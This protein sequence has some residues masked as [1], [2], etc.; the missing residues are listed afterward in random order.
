MADETVTTTEESGVAESAEAVESGAS[1]EGVTEAT[2]AAEGAAP[3]DG[4]QGEAPAQRV[5][6]A[7]ERIQ[8]LLEKN[9]TLSEQLKTKQAEAPAKRD[10]PPTRRDDYAD[11]RQSWKPALREHPGLK[12][13]EVSEDGLVNLHGMFVTSEFAA[14]HLDIAEGN[15]EAREYRQQQE[16]AAREQAERRNIEE[17]AE[18]YSDG[19][20]A[21][22]ES[23]FPNLPK[24]Q[25]EQ[26]DS[27]LCAMA[28][29]KI[30]QL[31]AQG[32]QI[33]S[34]VL[35]KVALEVLAEAKLLFGALGVAQMTGNT[36][37][38]NQNKVK[39]GGTPGTTKPKSIVDMTR[40]ERDEYTKWAAEE[41]VR[42]T[43]PG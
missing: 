17:I 35:G 9:K 4:S 29:Q 43:S 26:V 10:E 38:A 30:G 22:R 18:A 13:L 12:E 24:G 31:N 19:I 37:Y 41:A 39:P 20:S 8:Q 40:A 34:D 2:K 33:T 25:G 21:M 3:D 11:P 15:K 16:T 23:E 1:V 5:S 42:I 32:Q 14:H 36:K 27:W 7:N 6:R 28:N